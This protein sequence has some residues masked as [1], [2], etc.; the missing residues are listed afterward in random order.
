MI[1]RERSDA[2][3]YEDHLRDIVLKRHS[4]VGPWLVMGLG[5]ALVLFLFYLVFS[6]VIR[7]APVAASHERSLRMM[8]ETPSLLPTMAAPDRPA[9]ALAMPWRPAATSVP[10]S[11]AT[12]ALVGGAGPALLPAILS[13]PQRSLPRETH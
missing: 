4:P 9:S 2:D 12:N 8:T 10:Q 3:V 11:R 1:Y 5:A 13:V 6:N 7:P